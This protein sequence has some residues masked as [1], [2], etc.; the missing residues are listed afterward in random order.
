M[1]VYALGLLTDERNCFPIGYLWTR[2]SSSRDVN[3]IL[4]SKLTWSEI[5][6]LCLTIK[7]HWIRGK[8]FQ[9][10]T[11]NTYEIV[12]ILYHQSLQ[13]RQSFCRTRQASYSILICDGSRH[14]PIQKKSVHI[15]GIL[16]WDRWF[17]RNFDYFWRYSSL[18][19]EYHLRKR[20]RRLPII[21][22]ILLFKRK[23]RWPWESE[24]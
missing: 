5:A 18:D 20:S 16:W 12:W 17:S 2:P 14:C 3:I 19:W 7:K 11:W 13:D 9:P 4:L 21:K 22:T 10:W 1:V 24:I 8:L 6:L 15:L 23:L